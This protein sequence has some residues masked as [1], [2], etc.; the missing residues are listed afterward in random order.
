MR[1]VTLIRGAR[2][3]LTLR[4]PGGPRRGADLRNLGIIQDG[5]VLVVDG[6]IAEV[7]PTRRLENV[8][9]SRGAEE[10]DASGRLVM[11]GFV[12]SAI[13]LVGAGP[14]ICGSLPDLSPRALK[15]SALRTLDELVRCGTTAMEAKSGMGVTEPAELKILRL[16]SDL[17]QLPLTL[18]STFV[19]AFP[20]PAFGERFLFTLRKRK[21]ADF[22]E[23]RCDQHAFSVAQACHL[24]AA[25]RE[26]GLPVKMIGSEQPYSEAIAMAVD[27]GVSVVDDIAHV[28]ACDIARMAQSQTMATVSPAAAFNGKAECY[29]PARVLIDNGAAVALASGWQAERP[30]PMN[31]LTTVALACRFMNMTAAEA[32]T[33]ATI[34]GA[35]AIGHAATI[36][37]LETGKSAD[38]VMLDVSDY[39]ELHYYFG[40]DLV[41]TVMI[42]GAVVARKSEV[43]WPVR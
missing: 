30:A 38:I 5:A 6:R 16:Q 40:M 21:L 37:S 34:N 2:Q 1:K 4:G 20:D 28:S 32:I 35:H 13:Q 22:V 41:H 18:V 15:I 36:G 11:P 3:L 19:A 10:I 7:G 42:G 39:R 12:D 17:K 26:F 31:M 29:P 9:M 43:N 24:L 27:R 14:G 23:V 25:A 33:A 8:A